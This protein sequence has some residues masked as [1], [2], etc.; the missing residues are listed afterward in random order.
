[1]RPLPI[2]A[3]RHEHTAEIHFLHDSH[4]PDAKKAACRLNASAIRVASTAARIPR[5][6]SGVAPS[7][8]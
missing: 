5:C 6:A 8:C 1:M 4:A 3:R 7:G 2:E